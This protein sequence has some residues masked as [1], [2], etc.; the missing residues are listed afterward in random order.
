MRLVHNVGFGLDVSFGYA[1]LRFVQAIV[2]NKI[3][4]SFNISIVTCDVHSPTHVPHGIEKATRSSIVSMA[5]N[6]HYHGFPYLL[7]N[8][9]KEKVEYTKTCN[10]I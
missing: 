3:K 8:F 1:Y 2:S 5:P 9:F 6:T 7:F 10:I 4:K